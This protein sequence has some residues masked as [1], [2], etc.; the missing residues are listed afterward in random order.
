M[1]YAQRAVSPRRRARIAEV[2]PRSLPFDLGP[3]LAAQAKRSIPFTPSIPALSGL[4]ELVGEELATRQAHDQARTDYLDAALA[5]LGPEPRV[6]PGRRSRSV[7]LLPLPDGI[8]YDDLHD[9]LKAEGYVIYAGLGDA[10]QTTFRLRA[11][12]AITVEALQGFIAALEQVMAERP[13][14]VGVRGTCL[15]RPVGSGPTTRV[16]QHRCGPSGHGR[17]RLRPYGRA[18]IANG[19]APDAAANRDGQCPRL[20]PAH[21]ADA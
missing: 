4:D 2:P 11:P 3:Y 21:A 12:G 19:V 9:R 1:P 15:H 14:A 13:V 18:P 8:A 20:P 6:A 17:R 10:A 7:R 16:Q 5:R